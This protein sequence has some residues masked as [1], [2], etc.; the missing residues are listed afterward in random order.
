MK[1]N[2]KI[3]AKERHFLYRLLAVVLIT[4]LVVLHVGFNIYLMIE[5]DFN[6]VWW[7]IFSAVPFYLV[8]IPVWRHYR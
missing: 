7:Q 5:W 2:I 3:T 1:I 6:K 4:F 8:A